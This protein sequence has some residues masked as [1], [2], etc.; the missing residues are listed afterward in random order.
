MTEP[1][2]QNVPR[3]ATSHTHDLHDRARAVLQFD[4][5]A[6]FARAER[7]RSATHSAGCIE[8]GGQ[9]AWNVADYDFVRES[10]EAPD[11]VH[12]G[13]WRQARLNCVHGLFEV[14]DGVWQAR[15]YDIS[16][17][18]SLGPELPSEVVRT[19]PSRTSEPAY[20]AYPRG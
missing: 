3:A 20:F 12:P 17:H 6:D 9:T 7:G 19:S 8:L 2:D 5:P 11:T 15:G 4:D 10:Q 18:G 16:A 13:L 1:T 14:G